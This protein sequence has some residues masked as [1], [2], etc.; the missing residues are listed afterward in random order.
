M[1]VTIGKKPEQKITADPQDALPESSWVARRISHFVLL[2]VMVV[3]VGATLAI[4]YMLAKRL[5]EAGMQDAGT[6][7]A[8]VKGLIM[9]A[10]GAMIMF[11]VDNIL[12]KVAPS[13]EQLARII[14]SA[15]LMAKGVVF[16]T[17]TTATA[18]DDESIVETTQTV[19]KPSDEELPIP[20]GPPAPQRPE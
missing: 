4:L 16:R 9:I 6:M 19:G 2:G 18:T 13:A 15:S 7:M 14:K 10:T 12:Y 20:D 17:Q 5:L 11:S 1:T 3:V 8:I